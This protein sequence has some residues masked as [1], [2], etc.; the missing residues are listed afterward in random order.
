MVGHSGRYPDSSPSVGRVQLRTLNRY[1]VS[2]T[3]K[4]GY[5][6]G[7]PSIYQAS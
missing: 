2:P 3:V 5:R 4:P 6:S 1:V 7:F